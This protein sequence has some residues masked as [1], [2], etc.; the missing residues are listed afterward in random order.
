MTRPSPS[1]D[2]L[3]GRVLDGRYR[4][5]EQI[6]SGGMCVVYRGFDQRLE[7]T[8]AVKIAAER[9]DGDH[10]IDERFKREA[11]AIARLSDPGLV[12][13][14]DQGSVGGRPYLVLEYVA[15][16]TARELLAERGAMP[17]YA[18][19]AL[20]G[21]VLRALG[22]AHGFG[23]V[24]GDVKP[25]NI[26]ISTTGEV[27]VAD[28]GSVAPSAGAGRTQ[29]SGGGRDRTDVF[30]TVG[31]LAPEQV[32]GGFWADVSPAVDVYAVGVVLYEL[33]TGVL[34]F[35][36]ASPAELAR[37]RLVHD[38]PPPSRAVDGV[39]MQFDHLVLRATERDLRNRYPDARSM[40]EDLERIRAELGLPRYTVP[41]PA[42]TA[43]PPA[44]PA[45]VLLP[46]TSPPRTG[47]A[48]SAETQRF[49]PSSGQHHTTINLAAIA[50]GAEPEP[51]LAR[52][53]TGAPIL[54]SVHWRRT[55]VWLIVVLVFGAAAMIAGYGLAALVEHQFS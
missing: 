12:A 50:P 10:R 11:L 46:P 44:P 19:A 14:Y 15:G 54:R 4:L 24:H 51:E 39:P 37:A 1:S 21:P 52:L 16:G 23:F 43:R 18:T 32:D 28:F 45:I 13:V 42:V 35:S 5:D 7:R 8:V 48:P 25:E 2:P 9:F 31:Y 36:G 41:A 20:V 26:L 27:K 55:A 6:G 29:G 49:E 47:D 38:V 30:G 33:L 22:A 40:A 17:P 3:A 34:P 53:G